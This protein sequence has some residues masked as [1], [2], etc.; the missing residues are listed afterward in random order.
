M[1]K[2]RTI[3]CA[4]WYATMAFRMC[5]QSI[6]GTVIGTNLAFKIKY[7]I[8]IIMLYFIEYLDTK[9]NTKRKKIIINSMLNEKY[10]DHF[11]NAVNTK[12]IDIFVKTCDWQLI[13]IPQFFISR[14][15]PK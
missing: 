3:H 8:I 2:K 15:V 12:E 6:A 5:V 4:L 11:N 10:Y 7:H 14:V 1:R 13:D 9:K